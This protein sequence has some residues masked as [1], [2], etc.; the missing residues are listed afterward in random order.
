MLDLG[1]P[2]YAESI[3]YS[4]AILGGMDPLYENPIKIVR[5]ISVIEAVW[6]NLF[7]ILII[8]RLLSLP[9]IAKKE[10]ADT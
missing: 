2:S 9:L 7:A 6:G 4:M 3:Y 5:N 8:G 10:R 1:L